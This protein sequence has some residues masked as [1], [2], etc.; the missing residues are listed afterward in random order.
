LARERGSMY[1]TII[2]GMGVVMFVAFLAYA[3]LCEKM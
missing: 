1:D 2:L 3:F